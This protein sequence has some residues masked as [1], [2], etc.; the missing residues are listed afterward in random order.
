MHSRHGPIYPCVALLYLAKGIVVCSGQSVPAEAVLDL[1]PDGVQ[2]AGGASHASN[3]SD[4]SQKTA[5]SYQD[6]QGAYARTLTAAHR[7]CDAER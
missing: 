5:V 4:R 6:T 2:E 3:A 1:G 7:R